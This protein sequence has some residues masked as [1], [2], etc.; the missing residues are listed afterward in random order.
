VED[1]SSVRNTTPWIT[2]ITVFVVATGFALI[3]GYAYFW[4]AYLFLNRWP[5]QEQM[6]PSGYAMIPEAKQIDDLLGPA[7]HSISNYREPD[8][9]EW[10]TKALFG[11]RYEMEMTVDARVDRRSAKVIEV[12]G[13]P[14]FLLLEVHEII[15]SR[16]VGY[17]AAGQR[18]FGADEWQQVV[19]AKGDFTIIGIQLDRN[20]PVP[21]FN[22]YLAYPHNGVRMSKTNNGADGATPP[23]DQSGK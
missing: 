16:E 19:R 6:V 3:V 13:K 20:N 1:A 23:S 22:R 14:R 10:H 11:G 15:G 21:G 7:W 18:A 9:A 5:S 17:R 2:V 12:I 8:I 4:F